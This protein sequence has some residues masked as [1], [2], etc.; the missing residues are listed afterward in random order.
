MNVGLNSY[1]MQVQKTQLSY[2]ARLTKL[3]EEIDLKKVPN[4]L[5][6]K[7]LNKENISE[8]DLILNEEQLTKTEMVKKGLLQNIFSNFGLEAQSFEFIPNSAFS[9][10]YENTQMNP[11]SK[12]LELSPESLKYSSSDEYY[13][14]TSFSFQ[15][16]VLVN[17]PEGQFSIDLNFSYTQ[18]YYEANVQELEVFKEQASKPLELSFDTNEYNEE[19]KNMN[20]IS[21]LLDTINEKDESI[22]KSLF[23]IL[24]EQFLK[25]KKED[26]KEKEK[27][28]EKKLQL[29]NFKL[30]L[31]EENSSYN[32]QAVKKDNMGIFFANVSNESF[33]QSLLKEGNSISY[34]SSYSKQEMSFLEIKA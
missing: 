13:E 14:K 33:S 32:L 5:D 10:S 23:D 7:E 28:E 30:Y 21:I 19:L 6:E 31:K 15:G 20:N 27:Q 2:E 1:N 25:N 24:H 26:E 29:D 12:N 8:N 22:N 11:Y 17:T 9:F 4:E 18:E 16:Q 34:S 3:D